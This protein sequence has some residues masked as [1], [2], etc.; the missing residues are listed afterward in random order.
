M[1]RNDRKAIVSMVVALA[2]VCFNASAQVLAPEEIV[3]PGL[4]SLQA[5]YRPE[6]K[7]I[8]EA[9]HN[10]EFPFS[11][12][13]NRKLDVTEAQQKSTDQRSIQ[14]DNYDNRLVLK[15]TGNYYAAY[16]DVLMTESQRARATYENV[17][18]PILL[19]AI[20]RFKGAG[21]PQAFAIEISHHVRKKVLGVPDEEPENVVLILPMA[22]AERLAAAKNDAERHSAALEGEAF[23]NKNP[24]LLFPEDERLLM[25]HKDKGFSSSAPVAASS[26]VPPGGPK[27]SLAPAVRTAT[28]QATVSPATAPPAQPT[29]AEPAVDNSAQALKALDASH[30]AGVEKMLKEQDAQAHF[31]AYAPP[32]FVAFRD[33]AYLQLSV[34]TTLAEDSSASQYRL[35]ALAFDRHIAHLIRP[36]FAYFR[37]C[38]D[39]SGIDFSTSI[40]TGGG[41]GDGGSVAVEYIFTLA[42]IRRYQNFDL[43]GQDL[44]R[45][46]YILVNGERISLDLQE[47]EGRK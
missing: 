14:F 42:D 46:G 22:A 39:F 35:A 44:I 45:G 6:L 37:D 26:A 25:V 36:I 33:G 13:L 3:D 34:T 31:V 11:F 32:T 7:A 28:A 10:H 23:L 15:I 5:K 38:P 43:T 2:F 8:G 20:P 18:L 12:Y 4:R 27:P 24:V 29:P 19:E 1:H 40:R 17:M 47:A 30:Q 41:S 9:I 21:V 16:S